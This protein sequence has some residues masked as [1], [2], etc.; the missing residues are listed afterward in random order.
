M[1]LRAAQ[2]DFLESTAK[3]GEI[4]V[5]LACLDRGAS[6]FD[7]SGW[8]SADNDYR[9]LADRLL[10][11]HPYAT[12]HPVCTNYPR[13]ARDGPG[14]TIDTLVRSDLLQD[15]ETSVEAIKRLRLS[16]KADEA[17]LESAQASMSPLWAAIRPNGGSVSANFPMV[18]LL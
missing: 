3:L 4:E 9:T 1:A 10:P 8:P 17:K 15:D 7:Q 18:D 13:P 12:A 16:M 11:Y 6:Q 2:Q 14:F 5:S